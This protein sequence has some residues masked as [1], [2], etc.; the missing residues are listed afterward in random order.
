[1]LV[2]IPTAAMAMMMKNLLS[3]LSGPLTLAGSWH[4]VVMT[5][6]STKKS[7]KRGKSFQ[8]D[9][10]A[11]F[12]LGLAGAHQRQHQC[13]GDDGQRPGELDDGGS[14]Q[15]LE[16]WMPSRGGRSRYGRGVVDGGT[17]KQAKAGVRKP[18][19]PAQRRGR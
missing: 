5:A 9:F 11:V 2:F 6:A 16:P 13:D 4:T 17:G 18:Q 10:G 14:V 3:S 15:V 12:L 19:K 8:A 7:T 1:M